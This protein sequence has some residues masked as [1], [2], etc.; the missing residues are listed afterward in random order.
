MSESTGALIAAKTPAF[1]AMVTDDQGRTL[2][3]IAKD[4]KAG[5]TLG[6]GVGG[7]WFVSSPQGKKAASGAGTS[8]GGD[9]SG[10]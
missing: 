9:T 2:Y 5:D 10:Y 6:Q 8:T 1:A 3:R 7:T 4:T